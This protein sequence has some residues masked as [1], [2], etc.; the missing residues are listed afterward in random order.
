MFVDVII[1]F[2]CFVATDN[3]KVKNGILLFLGAP[4]FYRL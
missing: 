3:K 4:R 1:Y 2:N